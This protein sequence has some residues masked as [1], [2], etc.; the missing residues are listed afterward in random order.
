LEVIKGGKTGA[1]EVLGT[2]DNG[3]VGIAIEA[4]FW[5]EG[6][7]GWRLHRIQFGLSKVAIW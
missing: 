2:K 1:S 5:D 3:S 4:T 6:A 7:D